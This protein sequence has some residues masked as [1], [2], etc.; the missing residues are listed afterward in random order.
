MANQITGKIEKIGAVQVLHSKDGS[1]TFQKREII[2]DATRYDPYT[3]ERGFENYPSF[4]FGGERCAELDK[5][6]PGQVVTVS[7]DVFGMKYEDKTT[8]ETK[9]FTKVRGYRIESRQ[10]YAPSGQSNV[11]TQQVPSEPPTSSRQ[12][13]QTTDNYVPFPPP[14]DKD[15]IPLGRTDDL[16]F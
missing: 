15:G 11:S 6:K 16:P 7:F 13:K 9:Y 14:V 4:E 2:L 3:G 5:F 1:K 12:E 10:V 8:H